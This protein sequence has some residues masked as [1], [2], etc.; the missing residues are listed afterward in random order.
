MKRH[1][2]SSENGFLLSS[3][4]PPLT[5]PN[6]PFPARNPIRDKIRQAQNSQGSRAIDNIM[7]LKEFSMDAIG[8]GVYLSQDG[9]DAAQAFAQGGEH[10]IPYP[11]SPKR[12]RSS[13]CGNC[14]KLRVGKEL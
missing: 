3:S 14:S 12:R 10:S 2:D 6:E 1:M 7:S 4:T 8:R 9:S 11:G 5:L 13:N